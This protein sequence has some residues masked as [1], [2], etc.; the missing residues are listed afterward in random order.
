M[1][2]QEFLASF[3]VEV[4]ESGA[5]RL[6]EIL[7][8]NKTLAD[9]LS[10]AFAAAR[11]SRLTIFPWQSAHRDPGHPDRRGIRRHAPG[12]LVRPLPLCHH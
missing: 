3:G 4:D 1:P 10:R 8:E 9:D 2:I 11:S 7:K 12:R 6:Q 5:S